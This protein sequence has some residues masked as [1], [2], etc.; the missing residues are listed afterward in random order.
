MTKKTAYKGR[1]VPVPSDYLHKT[2]TIIS[3]LSLLAPVPGISL[4]VIAA[5]TCGCQ[6]VVSI[7]ETEGQENMI[8]FDMTLDEGYSKEDIRQISV[9]VFNTDSL[10]RLDTYQEFSGQEDGR[11]R[12]ATTG[13]RKLMVLC[14]NLRISDEELSG[15]STAEDLKECS[16]MLEDTQREY[17]LMLGAVETE[18]GAG[19]SPTVHMTPMTSEIVL[20]SVTCSFAGTPYEG[21]LITD[22]RVYLINVNA[23]CSLSESSKDIRRL[24]NI[25]MLN[26]SDIRSFIEPDIICQEL[27]HDIGESASNRSISLLCFHNFCEDESPG[28]PFTR[29]VIEGKIQ[30]STYYWPITINRTD[31]G[32]GVRN[33]SRHVFDLKIRQKGSLDP[34]TELSFEDCLGIMEI[35]EWNE[36]EAY[37]IFF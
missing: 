28:S 11:I 36:K 1:I 3:V 26:E 32:Q 12:A 9:F 29:M 16:F 18:T 23:Q 15:I 22:P 19:V 21:E 35:R 25:G 17:P 30:G 8:A 4:P 24:I 34:D 13:G 6:K 7:M 37:T 27:E 5:F 10:G 33:N 14:A 20:R 2:C 31:G